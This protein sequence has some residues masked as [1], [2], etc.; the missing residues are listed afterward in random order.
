M[1]RSKPDFPLVE[2]LTVLLDVR[3]GKLVSLGLD[4]FAVFVL[5]SCLGTVMN[6]IV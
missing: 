6:V 2:G 4:I 3:G 1:S 5:C